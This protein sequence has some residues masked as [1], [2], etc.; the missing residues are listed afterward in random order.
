MI[1]SGSGFQS[2]LVEKDA[3]MFAIL[4]AQVSRLLPSSYDGIVGYGLKE[5]TMIILKNG[6][7]WLS[8]SKECPTINI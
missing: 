2:H 7:E 4:N 5:S 1:L 8:L 6:L 3:E